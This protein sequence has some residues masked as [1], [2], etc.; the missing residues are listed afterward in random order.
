[1]FSQWLQAYEVDTQTI[2]TIYATLVSIFPIVETWQTMSE[3]LLLVCSM[4]PPNYS[5]PQ[6]RHRL[7]SEPFRTALTVS[8]AAMDLE[9]FFSRFVARSPLAHMLADEE[10]RNGWL[11]TDD[12]MLVEFGFARTVGRGKAF[13]LGDLYK[14]SRKHGEHRPLVSAGAVDWDQVDEHRLKMY[15]LEEKPIPALSWLTKEQR[16]RAKAYNSFLNGS[17]KA[18]LKAWEQQSRLPEHPLELAMIAEALADESDRNALELVEKLRPLWPAET[19]AVLARFY[20]KTKQPEK[21][22]K[23]LQALFRRLRYDP[24]PSR[25]MM[26]RS[27]YLA[28]KLADE[29]KDMTRRLYEILSVPFSVR[30]LDQARLRILFSLADRLGSEEAARAVKPFEPNV[31]WELHFLSRRASAYKE[32]NDPMA[33]QADKDLNEFLRNEPIKISDTIK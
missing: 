33:R 20:W 22:L 7:A 18:I 14:A 11:N 10:L 17:F 23:S 4:A 16:L 29:N 1:M 8:W 31:P 2:R 6:L 30:M 5:I 25:S 19:D 3:D 26:N 32:T 12:R 28:Q 27:L 21:A 13:T 24:W 9:G 15:V